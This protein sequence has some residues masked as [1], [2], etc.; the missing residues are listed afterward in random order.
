VSFRLIP[1]LWKLC[2]LWRFSI[3]VYSIAV[4]NCR[5]STS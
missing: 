1:R 2:R 4:R 3:E 5:L